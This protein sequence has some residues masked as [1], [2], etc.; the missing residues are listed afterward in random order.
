MPS[1]IDI[2]SNALVLIGDDSISSFTETPAGG[3]AKNLYQTTY[4]NL[5]ASHPWSFAFKEQELN[6][7]A[8]SPDPLTGFDN[9]FQLPTDLIRLWAIF[10]HSHYTIVGDILYSNQAKLLARYVVDVEEPALP[11]H[12]V[13]AFEFK[14]ASKLAIAIT[15][16][17]SKA[18]YYATLAN[19]ALAKAR[20]VDSQGRPQLPIIDSPFVNARA[21][22]FI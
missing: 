18:Q 7:L 3:V 10:P 1:D 13:E 6:M 19:N 8:Q 11:A 16:D 2:A 15:E 22:G 17:E 21:S 9:A 12:F 4:E 20:N 14:L 5:L